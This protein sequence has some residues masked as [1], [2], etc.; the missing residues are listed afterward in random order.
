MIN[1]N[2]RASH[3]KVVQAVLDTLEHLS[4]TFDQNSEEEQPDQD[5]DED[6]NEADDEGQ[7]RDEVVLD[8]IALDLFSIDNLHSASDAASTDG[9]DEVDSDFGEINISLHR[10]EPELPRA[11]SANS[12]DWDNYASD[13][14]YSQENETNSRLNISE[15]ELRQSF[16]DR[17]KDRLASEKGKQKVYHLRSRQLSSF[18]FDSDLDL[19][20]R[21]AQHSRNIHPDFDVDDLALSSSNASEVFELGDPEPPPLPPRAMRSSSVM[22]CNR[23]TCKPKKK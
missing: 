21:L 23:F 16:R 3:S 18:S 8:E 10:P 11:A 19:G 5:S 20:D 6:A 12:L 7:D 4:T 14:T 9:E 15:R 22:V 1:V 17:V 13:P 2:S